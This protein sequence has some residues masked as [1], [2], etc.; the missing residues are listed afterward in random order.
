MR[1]GL[2]PNLTIGRLAEQLGR[3][4]S[5]TSRQVDKFVSQGLLTTTYVKEISVFGKL[6]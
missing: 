4:Y 2:Q 1:G 5:S 6:V 3:D